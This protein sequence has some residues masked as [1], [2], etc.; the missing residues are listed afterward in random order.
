MKEQQE[1]VHGLWIKGPLTALEQLTICSFL[2]HGY[3]FRLWTYHIDSIHFEQDG[4]LLKDAHEI[5]PHDEIFS[6]QK[7]GPLGIGKGS[8]AGFSDIFRYKLLYEYGGWW[9]DMDVC[10]LK[11]FSV[12]NSY[13]F[14]KSKATKSSIV[15]NLM[16]VPAHSALMKACYERALQEIQED[17][18]DWMKPIH[19]L[20][21]EIDKRALSK[22]VG[23]IANDDSW[24]LVRKLLISNEQKPEHWSFIHWMNEEFR[25]LDIPKDQ[26]LPESI[27]GQ[28]MERYGLGKPV[29]EKARA[30]YLNKT[31]LLH[32][33]SVHIKR[34][35]TRQIL[36]LIFSYL[37]SSVRNRLL[38]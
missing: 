29:Q 28:L 32:Y 34:G 33:V 4:L 27:L 8:Y 12:T 26:Y 21:E 23:D 9:T 2:A 11:P 38:L 14:R 10:C 30:L 22:Y 6:Y 31:S 25:V 18:T 7:D 20:Q 36:S 1:I 24:T 13:V 16:K 5:I 3:S 37:V 35:S 15:G 19:I 17:N